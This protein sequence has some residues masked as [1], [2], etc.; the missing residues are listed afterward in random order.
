[1]PPMPNAAVVMGVQGPLARSAED[2]EL[3]LSV[4]AGPDVGEDVAW[5][6]KLPAPRHERLAD[7]RVAV[8]PPIPWH[9]V[10][11]QIEAALEDLASRLGRLGC[12]VRRAQPE[13]L[14]DHREHHALYRSLLSAVTSA[15]VDEETRRQ[16]V[17]MY[18]KVGR[19]VL[20]RPPARAPGSAR[21]TT[22]LWNGRRE[23]Y[24][25]G[26]RAFFQDWDVLLAPAINVLA[27]P[28]VER[29][30]PPDDSDLTLTFTVDGRPVPYL[31]GLVLP[32]A[33]HGGRPAR[34]RVPGRP[35][36]R[37]PADRAP[38]DRPLSRGPDADPLRPPARARDRRL[39]K[40]AGYDLS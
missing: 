24:R 4:L 18:E 26:W 8:L 16:R 37:G 9:P 6:V 19:R 21:A 15:R 13:I 22:S 14:G 1:M 30:W 29:A 17:A 23:Q 28:H 5:R 25:A 36:A 35:L 10:D 32:G 38:G 2:L 3:A 12:A 27:Y 40:P 7:F 31:H 11:D 34:H 33:V 39:P 20:A